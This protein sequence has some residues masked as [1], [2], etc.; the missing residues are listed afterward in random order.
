MRSLISQNANQKLE[1]FL[2]WKFI[3]GQDRNPSN[4]WLA[5]WEKQRPY[6]FI[7][8]LTD[9]QKSLFSNSKK[10]LKDCYQE[11]ENKTTRT[12]FL[13]LS[14]NVFNVGCKAISLNAFGKKGIMAWQHKDLFSQNQGLKTKAF[15]LH[16][17]GPAKVFKSYGELSLSIISKSF[18]SLEQNFIP[19][20]LL[21]MEQQSVEYIIYVTD[22]GHPMKAKIK[23]T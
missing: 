3:R 10:T 23:E 6:K 5:F 13:T 20:G 9:L 2:P 15:L 12:L 4:F 14:S 8:N 11:H 16:R 19:C 7:L 21:M 17:P 1:E 18:K 22:Y